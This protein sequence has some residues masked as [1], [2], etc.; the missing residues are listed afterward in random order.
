MIS[1]VI[2]TILWA[3]GLTLLL[4]LITI[5]IVFLAWICYVLE[6]FWKLDWFLGPTTPDHKPILPEHSPAVDLEERPDERE[7]WTL[8]QLELWIAERLASYD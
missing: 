7:H 6:Q 1:F 3:I 4:E 5:I 8:P 2:S